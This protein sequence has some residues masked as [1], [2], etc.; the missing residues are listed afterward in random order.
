M[1]IYK[2]VVMGT[3]AVVLGQKKTP[4]SNEPRTKDELAVLRALYETGAYSFAELGTLFG[5]SNITSSNLSGSKKGGLTGERIR[6]LVRKSGSLVSFDRHGSSG[7]DPLA[8]LRVLKSNEK[9]VS[10]K[11]LALAL[12][13]TSRPVYTCLKKLDAYES[14]TG[15][16][17]VNQPTCSRQERVPVRVRA[18][19]DARPFVQFDREQRQNRWQTGC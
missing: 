17:R 7:P 6:K 10:I 15:C 16:R 14:K 11:S 19:A 9:I 13:T 4:G 8:V 2:G 3:V 5:S 18:G 1:Y 12:G